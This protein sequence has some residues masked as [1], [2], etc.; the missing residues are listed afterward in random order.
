MPPAAKQPK[1]FETALQ[2]LEGLVGDM[3][4]GK[5][6]LEAALAAY[7]RGSEL[8]GYCQKTLD[9]AEQQ[10]K[11]LENGELKNLPTA[12]LKADD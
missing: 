2:D 10:V 9:A 5:L 4:S 1:D 11:L 7:Q 12:G 3:E 6:S 8:A